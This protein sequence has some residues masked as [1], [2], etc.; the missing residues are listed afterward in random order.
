VPNTGG[1][2][3]WKTITKTGVALSAGQHVVRVVM[4]ANGPGGSVA[5][6]NWFAVR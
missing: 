4:D 6:F 1:W 3:V 2:Q 5:N